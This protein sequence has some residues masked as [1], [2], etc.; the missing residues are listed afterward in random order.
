[1]LTIVRSPV[2]SIA[3]EPGSLPPH[4]SDWLKRLEEQPQRC[5]WIVPTGRRRRALLRNWLQNT[6]RSA[7]LLPGLHTIQSFAAQV[8]EYSTRQCPQISGLERLL[9][10]ARA[11]QEIMDRSPGVGLVRQLDRFIRDWQA[12]GLEVP[13][14]PADDLE[15]L[16]QRYCNGLETDQRLDPFSSLRLLVQEISDPESW[17]HRLFLERIKLILFDGFHRLE[18]LELKLIAALSG[19]CDVLAWLVGVPGQRSWSLLEAAVKRL[20]EEATR[21]I[22]IDYL[23]APRNSLTHLGRSLFPI[24]PRQANKEKAALTELFRLETADNVLEV[25]AAAKRIKADY[26]ASQKSARPLRLSDIAVVIPGPDYDPLIREIFPRNGLEF[27]LAGQALRVSSSRPARVL[28]AALQL[29]YGHW[30][31]DLLRDFLNQPLVKR[32]L[33]DAHRLH[34]LLEHRPRARQQLEHQV[35]TAAWDHYLQKL[36]RCIE[37]WDSGELELPEHTILNPDEFI[38]R[39]RDLADSLE[40]LIGSIKDILKPVAVIADLVEGATAL[41]AIVAPCVELLERLEIDQWLTPRRQEPE[42]GERQYGVAI[43]WVEFEKDQKAYY[44]L[45]EV[46]NTLPAVPLNRLPLTPQERPDAIGA[47]QLALE[48]ETYQIKTEDDAGVQL[49]ELREIRGL[50][51]RHVYALGLVDGQVPQLPEE[52]FL[53]GRRR[54]I[55]ALAE[56]LQHKETEFTYLF[57]QLFEAAEERLVLS[58]PCLDRQ[59]KNLPSPFLVAV[60]ERATLAPLEPAQLTTGSREAT[61]LLGRAARNADEETGIKREKRTRTG[62]VWL[63]EVEAAVENWQRRGARSGQIGMEAEPLLQA[64]FSDA[65]VFSPSELETYAAC[66]FRYFGS[67]VLK[68][69]ER[70]S[71]RTR[72]HYG[73]LVHRVFQT[74]YTQMRERLGTSDGVPLPATD[75]SFRDYLVEL[76]EKEWEQ[77][78]DGTLPPDLKKL[79]ACEQG[80]LQLFFDAIACIEADHGNLLNEFLLQH[81][82]GVAVRLGEDHKNR[83]VLLTGK[84]DRV[85]VRREDHTRA[86]ILDYKTGHCKSAT[87][88]R[89]K[90]KDG[91]MLQLPLYAAALQRLRTELRIIGGAYIH[92]CEK[93]TEAKK[94]IAPVG[95]FLPTGGRSVPVPFEAEQ[96]R[97]LALKLVGEIRDGNF[98]LTPHRP[99]Q[100]HTECT[101]YCDMKHAC[102]LPDGYQTFGWF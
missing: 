71:D 13:S 5:Q 64:L 18:R 22:V 89:A 102:R 79:F 50:R 101:P 56:Q 41:D 91:R 61:I 51:F 76:F 63:E 23:P 74:F 52:G 83:P 86:I 73:S 35:W 27:N 10:V 19:R 42:P 98:S 90:V 92:V 1:M 45:L 7:A 36:R 48:S 34:D 28:S 15:L 12:C 2:S 81:E 25:E 58:C 100:P 6:D 30:R 37:R 4:V 55:P 21:P 59:Q 85:D 29:V 72:W 82:N 31:H 84:I 33:V 65:H 20:Q 54:R 66:P 24:E 38:D 47:L 97:R 77:L 53:A 16:V 95:E 32:K 40:R 62:E 87:E 80:V 68:L 60:R 17:P 43:P 94:A 9:R 93:L 67:R 14:K 88:R 44:K 99:G 11:W 96:A 8:L 69:E 3:S 78:D 39:Q 57:S 26:L 49:F 70:D 46:L 75:L